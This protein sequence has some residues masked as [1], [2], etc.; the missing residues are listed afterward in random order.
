MKRLFQLGIL[1]LSTLFLVCS[2]PADLV[3]V[4]D[5]NAKKFALTGNDSGSLINSGGSGVAF[6]Q[7]DGLGGTDFGLVSYNNDLT[8]SVTPGTPG[9]GGIDTELQSNLTNGGLVSFVLFTDTPGPATITGNGIFWT[10][11]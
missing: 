11:P 6:W 7:I 1:S 8:F 5:T 2:V 10:T 9:S 4:L 3:L